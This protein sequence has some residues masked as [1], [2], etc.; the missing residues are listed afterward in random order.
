MIRPKSKGIGNDRLDVC[1]VDQV[2]G[3][4]LAETALARC[5]DLRQVGRAQ[6]DP[7]EE[8]GVCLSFLL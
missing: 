1:H 5:S 2:V 7:N 4:A 3:S 8:G 6:S